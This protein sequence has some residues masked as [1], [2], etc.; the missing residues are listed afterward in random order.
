M[1]EFYNNCMNHLKSVEILLESHQ[2]PL[3]LNRLNSIGLSSTPTD[4]YF[5]SEKDESDSFEPLG[6]DNESADDDTSA[7]RMQMLFILGRL[8]EIHNTPYNNKGIMALL[9]KAEQALK[10]G[11][12]VEGAQN[13]QSVLYDQSLEFRIRELHL[14]VVEEAKAFL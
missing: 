14:Q 1:T 8:K 11:R 3:V 7:M 13:L 6:A 4:P 2:H 9:I 10:E 5:Y 12:I